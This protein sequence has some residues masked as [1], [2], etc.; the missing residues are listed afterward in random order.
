MTLMTANGKAVPLVS[1][2]PF[3]RTGLMI[4]AEIDFGADHLQRVDQGLKC[5]GARAEK[6]A[7]PVRPV[8]LISANPHAVVV[9]RLK[10]TNFDLSIARRGDDEEGPLTNDHILTFD[11]FAQKRLRG[12][13]R[14]GGAKYSGSLEPCLN[15]WF[16][17]SIA[18]FRRAH[19]GNPDKGFNARAWIQPDFGTVVVPA[20]SC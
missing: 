18:V 14:R 2:R 5:I 9:F 6:R 19:W 16:S 7:L 10:Q 3:Q 8:D 17:G 4:C 15:G 1:F 13:Q 12:V 20:A 11:D